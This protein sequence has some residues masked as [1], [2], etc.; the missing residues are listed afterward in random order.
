MKIGVLHC[1]EGNLLLHKTAHITIHKNG[2]VANFFATKTAIQ[3][4]MFFEKMIIG[5]AIM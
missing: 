4:N 1:F 5:F 2:C 3:A